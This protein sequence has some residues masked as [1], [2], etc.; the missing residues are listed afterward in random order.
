MDATLIAAPPSMKSREQAHDPEMCQSKKG[1]QWHF[2]MKVYIGVD[3]QTRLIHSGSMT[4]GNVH[5][6]RSCQTSCM[7]MRL[8]STAIVLTRVENTLVACTGTYRVEI[9]GG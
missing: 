8:D 9:L 1:N 2:G 5:E 4:L 3:S 7:V 6:A